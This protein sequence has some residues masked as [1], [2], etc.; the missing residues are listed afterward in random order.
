[1]DETFG[2]KL[3][4]ARKLAGYKTQQSLG[5][6]VGVS[7]KTIRNWETG[8]TR[9]ENIDPGHRAALRKLVGSFDD[10]GDPVEVALKNS[11]LIEWRWG[12]V[13]NEYKRHLHEQAREQAG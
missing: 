2:A 9:P 13:Y 4:R 5:D 3:Q 11:G 10:E 12:A 8:V 6:K 7:G 1:M